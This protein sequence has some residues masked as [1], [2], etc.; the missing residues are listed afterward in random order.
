M[1]I[2]II[3]SRTYTNKTQ[4]KNFMFRLKMEHPNVEVVSGGAK[5]GADKYAKKFALEFKIPYSEFPPQHEPHNMHC[6]MEAYNYGKPYGVGY[7]E[8]FVQHCIRHVHVSYETHNSH[9]SEG[10]LP[11]RD[12]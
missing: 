6:V 10:W 4:I 9:R 3:G 11:E 8:F 1:K 2:A 5:D 7:L 12:I